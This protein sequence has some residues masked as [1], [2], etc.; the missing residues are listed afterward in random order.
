MPEELYTYAVARIRSRELFLLDSQFIEQLMAAGSYEECLRL[1]ADKGWGKEDRPQMDQLLADERDK[2]WNLIAELV[3]DMS[4]FDVFLYANDYHNL[5]TAV[6]LIYRNTDK[7]EK[8]L[9]L[10]HGTTDPALILEAIRTQDF[11]LLPEAMRKPGRE[12][13]EA[14]MHTR[15]GQLCDRIV[16]RAALEAIHQAGKAR[17]NE[18]LRQYAELTVAAADIKI[19][20]RAQKIGKSLEWICSALAPCD[21]LDVGRL[22]QA[23]ASGFHDICEYLKHTVYVEGV[24]ELEHSLSAFERWCDNRLIREIRPQK[25]NPFTVSPL[26]AFLL[27]RENEIKTVRILLLGKRNR[28]PEESIRERLREMY[29]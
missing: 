13:Y 23:A 7:E 29:V 16:D 24:E 10:N 28:L 15:D 8:R 5:K 27:A 9:F 21:T 17:D 18:L 3:E 26:A 14:L 22:S 1:L 4:V 25:Y 2:A 6:K 20:V 11:L 12:A 19:A